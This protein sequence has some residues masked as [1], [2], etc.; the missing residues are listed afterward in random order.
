MPMNTGISYADLP[1]YAEIRSTELAP[2]L[3]PYV[4]LS[5]RYGEVLCG[6]VV[7]LGK[8]PPASPRDA[9]TRDLIADVFDFLYEARALIIKGK[10]EI[11][12][13]LA[14]RA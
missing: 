10:L 14:R 12:Y 5:D 4:D 1:R 8:T 11:A 3:A 9:A 7:I 2:L 13:P 6:F